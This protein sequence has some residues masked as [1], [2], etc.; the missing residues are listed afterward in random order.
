VVS[1][2][3]VGPVLSTPSA[4]EELLSRACIHMH[5]AKEHQGLGYAGSEEPGTIKWWWDLAMLARHDMHGSERQHLV[6]QLTGL[7]AQTLAHSAPQPS[8]ASHPHPASASASEGGG[9]TVEGVE[10]GARLPLHWSVREADELTRCVP[11]APTRALSRPCRQAYVCHLSLPRYVLSLSVRETRG[12]T[13]DTETHAI[14][15][16]PRYIT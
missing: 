12:E 3:A 4:R 16:T 15:H 2:C 1:A 9:D 7:K 8:G 5:T 10:A 6:Q 13:H 14:A 11:R